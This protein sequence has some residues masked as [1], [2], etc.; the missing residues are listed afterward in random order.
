MPT[1][2]QYTSVQNVH[3]FLNTDR[4][5]PI[6]SPIERG[7]RG[8]LIPHG[9]KN[10]KCLKCENCA[11]FVPYGRAGGQKKIPNLTWCVFFL[12][13]TQH[14]KTRALGVLISSDPYSDSMGSGGFQIATEV[15]THYV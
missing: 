14:R 11:C 10:P 7:D 8:E 1:G 4:Q 3:N 2:G 13:D 6:P 15:A 12:N 5:E 9:F